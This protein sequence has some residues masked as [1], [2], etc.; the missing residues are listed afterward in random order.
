MPDALNPFDQPIL[1]LL[2]SLPFFWV[3]AGVGIRLRARREVSEEVEGDLRFV[4]GGALTLLGLL[5]GF[6][7]SMAVGRY[8]QRKNYEEEE[9][10]AI[11]TEYARAQLL[12]PADA[13]RL[14]GLMRDYLDQ[15][16]LFYTS[17]DPAQLREIDAQTSRLQSEMWSMVATHA[18]ADPTPV[19]ALVAAGMND[20]LNRQGYTQ[21]AWWNR[22]PVS[23]WG[24]L[25][26]MAM[27][28]NLLNGFG[29]QGR[30]S[31]SLLWILPAVL[32]V[33]LFFMAD[34][35]APRGGIILVRPQNL[36]AVSDSMRPR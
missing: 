12:P 25:L 2:L 27:F 6:T 23:A 33:T 28:C 31:S 24:L 18:A 30:R 16:I 36:Q 21:A 20:V 3:A 35:E 9:A 19:S 1:L 34:I 4:L 22:I 26:S 5:I 32:S 11:G 15:R 29:T 7:F 17:R 13:T 14:R 8:D 10:N